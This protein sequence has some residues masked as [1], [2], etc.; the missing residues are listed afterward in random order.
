[1]N[2]LLD[3]LFAAGG[4][5]A[6]PDGYRLTL[7][8]A[9]WKKSVG[10]S[11][12]SNTEVE[13]Y[14]GRTMTVLCSSVRWRQQLERLQPV[15]IGQLAWLGARAPVEIHFKAKGERK[16]AA[17]SSQRRHAP[18]VRRGRVTKNKQRR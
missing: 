5:M 2:K 18:A 3:V 6:D 7:I 13:Q 15:I 14:D 4:Q 17:G 16:A 11:I 8:G 1:M 9:A 10:E 12:G